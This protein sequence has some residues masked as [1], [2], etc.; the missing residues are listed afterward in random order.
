M[1]TRN[2]YLT[3]ILITLSIIILN[4]IFIQYWLHQKRED[5]KIIN[6]GGKQRMLSQKLINLSY[7]YRINA[8]K[9]VFD[10]IN[11]TFLEWTTSHQYLLESRGQII[12]IDSK[13]SI[14]QQL[15]LLKPYF[16]K[17]KERIT[18]LKLLSNV[19][20]KRFQDNQDAYL[21]KM[22]YIVK[23]LEEESNAKLN[24]VIWFEL[25]FA[26]FSIIMVI[27]EIMFVFKKINNK[28]SKQN[29]A[30]EES[31]SLLENYAYLAAHD[32][33]SPTQNII[34]FIQLLRNKL[35]DRISNQEK[36]FID[37][38][39]HSAQRLKEITE[40]LLQFSTIKNEKVQIKVVNPRPIIENIIRDLETPIKQN[41]AEIYLKQLPEFIQVDPRLFGLAIQN[42]ISNGVKFKKK[43]ER[44]V[45]KISSRQQGG[46]TVFQIKDNGIGIDKASQNKIFKLFNRLNN[47]S[48]YLGTG[49]GLSICKK[50]IEKHRGKI[51]VESSLGLGS[52]FSI[53]I[54][55]E[56]QKG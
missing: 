52:T 23:G 1:N 21:S 56:V 15:I 19:E 33:R 45:I 10:K 13:D 32:L 30:L 39:S 51:L 48:D 6:V 18:S 31:N 26:F 41:N 12:G 37:Y 8:E 42:L 9:N 4:Q 20:M 14:F 34:N 3:S 46:Y 22:D 24:F 17:S 43:G 54:P 35:S 28:L 29:R 7:D 40:A 2:I 55:K 53:Y 27:Y 36:E 11:E 47:E 38:I 49:I 44:S 16:E 5:A 25:F 50:I